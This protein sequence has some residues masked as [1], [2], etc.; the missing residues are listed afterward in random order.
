MKTQTNIIIT[1]QMEG[2]HRWDGAFE[3]VIFLSQ[4]H[5][6]IFHFELEAPVGHDD[7]DI[8]II[9][10]KRKVQRILIDRY[11]DGDGVLQFGSKSCEMI[12]KEI[13]MAFECD[14]V[15]VTED[16]ENGAVIYLISK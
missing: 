12:A 11:G 1:F 10:F 4:D 16:G 9:L 3:E 7:R 14:R 8:E 6:H 15:K 5:R 2:F 13:L